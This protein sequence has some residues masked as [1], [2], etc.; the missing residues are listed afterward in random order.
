MARGVKA[1]QAGPIPFMEPRC[2]VLRHSWAG[3]NTQSNPP[4]LRQASTG[5]DI[6]REKT[7]SS[8]PSQPSYVKTHGPVTAMPLFSASASSVG[9]IF[10]A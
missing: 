5:S 3:I 9:M 4:W 2:V 7:V 10:S 1:L 6:L 8:E